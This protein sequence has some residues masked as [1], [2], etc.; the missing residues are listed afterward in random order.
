MAF[1]ILIRGRHKGFRLH[2]VM[3]LE[4]LG[5]IEEGDTKIRIYCIKIV[6]LIKSESY[7]RIN[8]GK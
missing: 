8:I 3:K 7:L 2:C 4:N 6:L 5:R 1:C